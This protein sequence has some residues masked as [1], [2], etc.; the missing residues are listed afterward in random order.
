MKKFFTSVATIV[1]SCC[2]LSN[3]AI[4]SEPENFLFESKDKSI[5][6][7]YVREEK[8]KVIVTIHNKKAYSLELMED[9]GDPEVDFV[10]INADKVQDII[11]KLQDESGFEPI[12]LLS[13]SKSNTYTR[14]LS[15]KMLKVD[16]TNLETDTPGKLYD[17]YKIVPEVNGTKSLVFHHLY[18]GE[19]LKYNVK[20]K[21]NEEKTDLVVQ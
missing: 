1:F 16:Y 4:G 20:L 8:I 21:L 13:N 2:L 10:D 11:L 14:A 17:A 5:T 12:I 18:I 15:Q 3:I 19:T 6:L 7:S 9:Y